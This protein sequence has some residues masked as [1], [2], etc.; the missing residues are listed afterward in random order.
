VKIILDANVLVSALF[1]GPP[2]LAVIRAFKESVYISPRIEAE[3][4]SLGAKL[5]RRLPPEK[6]KTWTHVFLP[7]ILGRC[8]RVG[9]RRKV[10]I[11]R[12]P[13]D[14][15]YLS[16]ALE[17]GADILVTGDKDL[18]VLSENDLTNA[19]LTHLKILNPRDFLQQ[20]K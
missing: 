5:S 20:Y 10:D 13:K 15:A 6:F 16:L 19:G 18:L 9:V 1:G 14:N 3:F 11:C 8:E 4:Q 2:R 17:I 7:S 12:D